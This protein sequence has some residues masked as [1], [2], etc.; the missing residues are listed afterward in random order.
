M[1]HSVFHHPNLFL[2]SSS[3]R[4]HSS[5]LLLGYNSETLCKLYREQISSHWARGTLDD[6]P[7]VSSSVLSGLHGC[8][9]HTGRMPKLFKEAAKLLS[10]WGT[11][12]RRAWCTPGSLSKPT[13][14][15]VNGL[16]LTYSWSWKTQNFLYNYILVLLTFLPSVY[17]LLLQLT[18]SSNRLKTVP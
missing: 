16:I 12:E 17:C 6:I 18:I 8:D 11:S 7:C 3:N 13:F 15:T 10:C 9:W 1:E 2:T 4:M 5:S 14:L